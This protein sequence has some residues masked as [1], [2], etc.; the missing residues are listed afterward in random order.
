MK[1]IKGHLP[2]GLFLLWLTCQS[3]VS[4]SSTKKGELKAVT[5]INGDKEV[6]IRINKHVVAGMVPLYPADSIS[7]TLNELN[8]EP[9]HSDDVSSIPPG[10]QPTGGFTLYKSAHN[11]A[12]SANRSRELEKLRTLYPDS[13]GP[14]IYDE[15]GAIT[16]ILTHKIYVAVEPYVGEW[17]IKRL[18]KS[19]KAIKIQ[20]AGQIDTYHQ[21]RVEFPK[22]W[23]YRILDVAKQIS[24][25]KKV[26][27][28]D[29]QIRR[30]MSPAR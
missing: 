29:H 16:G 25:H 10:G 6:T 5:M 22:S 4:V 11:K 18:L 3:M 15:H 13:F 8:L 30:V 2:L 28:V 24:R 19:G 20:R 9:Y 1:K 17:R 12:I 14:G 7:K 23:G 27:Y 26:K 21:Y